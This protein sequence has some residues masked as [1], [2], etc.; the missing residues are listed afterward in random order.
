MN[1]QITFLYLACQTCQAKIHC[2]QCGEDVTN[3]LLQMG[4]VDSVALNMVA[5]TLAV[6]GNISG[7]DLEMKL[8]DLGFLID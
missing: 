2:E 1:H 7:D 6:S 5:K 3:S 4:G 8:E